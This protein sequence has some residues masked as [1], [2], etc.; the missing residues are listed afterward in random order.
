MAPNDG[1]STRYE[2]E[3]WGM[4]LSREI[5]VGFTWFNAS[6][7]LFDRFEKCCSKHKVEALVPLCK[8]VAVDFAWFAAS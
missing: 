3:A 7:R 8:G 2:V 6:F 5:G 1:C 4:D